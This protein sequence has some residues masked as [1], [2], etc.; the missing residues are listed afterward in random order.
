MPLSVPST[1]E[2]VSTEEEPAQ[3]LDNLLEFTDSL[4]RRVAVI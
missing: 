4:L 2:T 3:E 1:T